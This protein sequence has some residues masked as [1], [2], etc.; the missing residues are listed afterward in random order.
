[1][2]RSLLLKL[3][4]LAATIGVVGWIAWQMP[5]DSGADPSSGEEPSSATTMEASG[6][7]AQA[8]QE[9]RRIEKEARSADAPLPDTTRAQARLNR[10]SVSLTPPVLSTPVDLNRADAKTLESLPGIGAV[11]AQRVIDYRTVKGRFHTVDD[12]RGVKGI[13][14]KTLERLKPLVMISEERRTGEG[15]EQPS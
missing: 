11:L 6:Q 8:V 15:G 5:D 1:M 12:L 4:M 7:A 9:L 13:G 14:P 10:R 2:I 3:G